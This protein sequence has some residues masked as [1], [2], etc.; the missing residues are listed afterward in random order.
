[1]PKSFF[2]ETIFYNF[3]LPYSIFFAMKRWPL[4]LFLLLL[5]MVGCRRRPPM[6][7]LSDTMPDFVEVYALK[8]SQPDSAMRLMK[9]IA[10]RL[11][12]SELRQR[13][14]FLYNEYQV[15]KTE[16]RYKTYHF[17]RD[18]T[19]TVK[20]FAFYD[21]LVM[22]ARAEHEEALFY[23]FTRALYYKAVVEGFQGKKTESFAD[24]LRALGAIDGLAGHRRA[25]PLR[26]PIQEYEHFAALTYERLA[27]FFYNYDEWDEALECLTM[28]NEC[29]ELEDCREGLASNYELM[30]DVM[31]AQGDR[32]A[33]IDY[34]E[35]SDSI[36]QLLGIHSRHLF[37]SK[38]LHDGLKLYNEG[39][40]EE[41]NA[42]LNSSLQQSKE[43][44]IFARRLHF[45]MGYFHFLEQD[46]DSALYHYERSF[47]QSIHHS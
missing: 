40:T 42:L 25:F 14:P 20:A 1:M 39:K 33:S 24:F 41:C 43:N 11:D 45:V 47:F 22:T 9:D 6:E 4:F 34:Y 36:Y 32:Y 12:E 23:Q 15:L 18:D 2:E 19:L 46:Y 10:A 17:V 28:S 5:T 16:L 31:L 29:F 13:S 38:T 35:K 37:Y 7:T 3:A 27:E 44:C 21:S 30:G 8:D 26:H